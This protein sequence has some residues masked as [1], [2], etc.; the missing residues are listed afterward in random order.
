M[1]NIFMTAAIKFYRFS[2][3]V[4]IFMLNRNVTYI[5]ATN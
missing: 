4:A 5:A 2:I 3:N 1:Y